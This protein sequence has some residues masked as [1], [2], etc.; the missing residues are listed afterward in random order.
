[1]EVQEGTGIEDEVD[2]GGDEEH[3]QDGQDGDVTEAEEEEMEEGEGQEEGAGPETKLETNPDVAEAA[4][5]TD[6]IALEEDDDDCQ[7]VSVVSPPPPKSPNGKEGKDG[8]GKGKV[9]AVAIKGKGG[10]A[11]PEK[12]RGKGP[13]G[14]GPPGKGP[15]AKHYPPQIAKAMVATPKPKP[16]PPQMQHTQLPT[17]P[18]PSQPPK[19]PQ[20]PTSPPVKAAPMPQI[21]VDSLLTEQVRLQVLTEPGK[22]AS[23]RRLLAQPK[24]LQLLRHLSSSRR[25]AFSSMPGV[26]CKLLRES[27][28]AF[29]LSESGKEDAAAAIQDVRVSLTEAGEA[30]PIVDKRTFDR[31][32]SSLFPNRTASATSQ[33]TT[34]AESAPSSA[35]NGAFGPRSDFKS[36][37][38]VARNQSKQ[39]AL[40]QIRDLDDKGV[41]NREADGPRPPSMPPPNYKADWRSF[42]PT[43]KRVP[44]PRRTGSA[45]SLDD[46]TVGTPSQPT[47]EP[48]QP[49]RSF[50]S[51]PAMVSSPPAQPAPFSSSGGPRPPQSPHTYPPNNQPHQ[52]AGPPPATLGPRPHLSM[53]SPRSQV[54]EPVDN[55]GRPFDLERVVVNFANVGATY[56]VRVLKRDKQ[57]SYLFDYEGV[58]RCVRHL[59]QKCKLRVIGVIFENFNGDENGRQV[60]QVPADISAMCESIELTPRLLGQRHKSADDEMTIKCAY[61]RN[62]RFLDNDN[63]QD[64]RNYLADEAVRTWLLHCQEFLQM[65]FYFDS[66]LGDFDIL[67]GNIPAA[68]LAQGPAKRMCTRP[69]K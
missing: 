37:D 35:P 43:A 28:K 14:K 7:I 49:A 62:C 55:E 34:Q 56:G 50:P 6:P 57:T 39:R 32:F 44:A 21:S 31:V 36:G 22:R 46:A 42:Q 9:A 61:R 64:W 52:P 24:V 33:P 12:G 1:M 47:H 68:W 54:P 69:W 23:M 25:L 41:P 3:H 19:P 4:E 10:K 29:Q 48:A 53:A 67:E 26:L 5:A 17:P 16:Q 20:P 18:K 58:R 59:T 30:N 11:P 60:Y 45:S 8:K 15:I 51:P 65:K 2:W 27:T 66:G 40:Q 63:Y 38:V 13:P